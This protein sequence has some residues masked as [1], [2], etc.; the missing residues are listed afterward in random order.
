MNLEAI[1][2]DVAF[3]SHLALQGVS[4]AMPPGRITAVIGPNAAGKTTLLR[5][6]AGVLQPTAGEVR[7]GGTGLQ[8]LAAFD[9]AQRIAY[10][11]QRSVVV[12]G[13]AVGD[14]VGFGGLGRRPDETR[15]AE[16]LARVGLESEVSRPF[17]ELSAGQQVRA[18]LARAVHQVE[19]SADGW[20]VL[21]EPFAAQ[22]PKE[23]VRL[24]DLL[25][26]WRA[27]GGAVV[28]AIHDLRVA[29]AIADEVVFL[30][31]GRLCGT[32]TA[33]EILVADRLEAL[34]D[35]A[36]DETDAGPV[37]RLAPARPG[38]VG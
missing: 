33:S 7:L 12:G 34:F 5:C 18:S 13:H 23:V 28:I 32:G 27:G 11:G 9:R 10:L 4:C 36:F 15:I 1:D 26:T 2:V 22:D 20:L 25:A 14:V 37:A 6:L 29:R 17:H 31:D 3:G 38:V 21:D 16:A 24:L 30:R 19:C 8:G 35:V